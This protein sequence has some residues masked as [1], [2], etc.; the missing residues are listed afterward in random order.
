MNDNQL[1][2]NEDA[3]RLFF[4]DEVYLVE[5]HS[6]LTSQTKPP[7]NV[8]DN[9][10]TSTEETPADKPSAAEEIKKFNFEYLGK[11]EKK[12]LILVDDPHHKVSDEEGTEFLRKILKAINYKTPDFALVNMAFYKDAKYT[13]LKASFDFHTLISFGVSYE[14]LGLTPSASHYTSEHHGTKV[15]VSSLL[16]DLINDKANKTILWKNFQQL[17]L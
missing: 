16:K 13:D 5:D 15:I 2:N 17:F 7:L 14:S 8:K 12:V 11:N 9:K 6:I 4:N 3:L 1:I 10:I